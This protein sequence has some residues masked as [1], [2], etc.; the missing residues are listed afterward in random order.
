ME[1][2]YDGMIINRDIIRD[3]I[4]YDGHTKQEIC[5]LINRWKRLLLYK[6]NLNKGDKVCVK[7]FPVDIEHVAV[8]IAI[9][10]LGMQVFLA[11][12]PV[13]METVHATKM[14]MHGPVDLT[15]HDPEFMGEPLRPEHYEMVRRY[16]KKSCNRS[17][18]HEIND[19]TDLDEEITVYPDDIFISTSTSGTSKTSR[20]INFTHHD[21]YFAAKTNAE[22]TIKLSE[23]SVSF[24]T[25]NMHHVGSMLSYLFPAMM[26]ARTHHS[27]WLDW[28]NVEEFADRL[29]ETKTD[30]TL[31]HALHFERVLAA[32]Q[33][34]KDKIQ[35]R[36]T[37]SVTGFPLN[38]THYDYCKNVPVNFNTGYGAT[39]IGGPFILFVDDT[40]EYIPNNIGTVVPGYNVAIDEDGTWVQSAMW[41]G[42]RRKLEDKI[43][44][45]GN[46]YTFHGRNEDLPKLHPVDFRPILNDTFA[47]WTLLYRDEE[48]PD[49]VIWD[50][51]E[52][53]D[54]SKSTVP[55][56][57]FCRK[58]VFLKKNDFMGETKLNMEQVRAYVEDYNA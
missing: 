2:G 34:R 13:C 31:V 22:Q 14:A 15:I 26:T 50:E 38:Q 21:A 40:T 1:N 45:H 43:Q 58:I 4:T 44:F 9:A 57:R 41:N 18:I 3:D 16:S 32:L 52:T 27:M 23:D 49:L 6:Y 36:I 55:L 20:P 35:N 11:N 24:N 17:E 7:L 37:F 51:H 47:D 8:V 30:S 33:V 25:V 10:E 54:F 19:D 53:I 12:K 42:E 46:Y 39:E 48:R 29:I 56:D 5:A 28:D